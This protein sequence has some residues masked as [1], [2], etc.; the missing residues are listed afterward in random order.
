MFIKLKTELLNFK[1]SEVLRNIN[2]F[3]INCLLKCTWEK[4]CHI[5]CITM[6]YKK[7]SIAVKDSRE[8][9]SPIFF[10]LNWNPKGRKKFF[11]D[12]PPS[13]GLDDRPPL[14]EGLD[15]GLDGIPLVWSCPF[16][17][18]TW[19]LAIELPLISRIPW[20]ASLFRF[21]SF[22]YWGTKRRSHI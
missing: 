19:T 3:L 15:Q 21:R 18:E 14:S 13:L 16:L 12:P 4:V 6:L 9:A 10:R 2:N 22:K 8:G 17:K 1:V 7:T 5:L 20:P 11:W